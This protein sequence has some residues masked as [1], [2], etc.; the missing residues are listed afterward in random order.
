MNLHACAC[1]ALLALGSWTAP[2]PPPAT[3]GA[4]AADSV[5]LRSQYVPMP[6][7]VRLAV[8]LAL[9]TGRRPARASPRW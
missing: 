1:A 5:T 3:H 4:A 9:P 6:D 7:G 2:A 8:D